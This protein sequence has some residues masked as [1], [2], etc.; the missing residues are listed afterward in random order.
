MM[1]VCDELGI[2]SELVEVEL[3]GMSGELELG[4]E[5]KLGMSGELEVKVELGDDVEFG[6]SSE[7]IVFGRSVELG[8]I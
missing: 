5:V 4:N 7:V 8:G 6:M 2:E 1:G 3:L